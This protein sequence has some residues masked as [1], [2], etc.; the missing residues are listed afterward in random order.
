MEKVQETF[1]YF[2]NEIN[3]LSEKGHNHLELY[4]FNR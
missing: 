2:L 1:Q 4:L 3:K